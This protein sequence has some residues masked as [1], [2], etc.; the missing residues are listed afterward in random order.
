VER[1]LLP[2][3]AVLDLAL[4][5]GLNPAPLADAGWQIAGLEVP[6]VT[7][8]GT[9]VCD[10]VL[11]NGA[12]GHLLVVEAKSGV[13][14]EPDQARKLAVIDPQDLIV[15]GGITVPQPVP[16]RCEPLFV[17]LS[18]N[19]GRIMIGIGATGLDAPVLAADEGEARLV[20]A[21]SASP[22]LVAVL[23][24]PIALRYPIASIIRFDHQS[25]DDAFDGPVRVE[26]VA[27]MARGRSAVTIRALTEQ[28]TWH[29]AVYGR[30]AQGQLVRKVAAAARRA[31]DADP[32]RLRF[33]PATGNTEAR[34]VILRSPEEFDRRG[35]TQG[36]QAVFGER[37]RRPPP[38]QIPDQLEL[39]SVL[40]DAERATTDDVYESVG[41]GSDDVGGHGKPDDVTGP[42]GPQLDEDGSLGGPDEV[43]AMITR[44]DLARRVPLDGAVPAKSFVVEVHTDDPS[45]Y[46]SEIA[47]RGN[48]EPTKDTYLSRVLVPNGEFWVDR[49]QQRFWVFHTIMP[50]SLAASWLR[51]RVESRRDTD[52][53]WL[54]SSHLRHIAPG[55]APHRV[56]TDFDG[57]RLVAADDAAYDLRVQLT[58]S[59]AERLLDQISAMPEYRAAV[60]FS[61]VEVHL[62]DSELGALREAVKRSGL[63]AARGDDFA[64]HAQFVRSAIGRYARFVETVEAMAMGFSPLPSALAPRMATDGEVSADDYAGASFNGTPIGIRFSRQ[65]AD[66]AGFCEEVFSSRAPFRLWGQPMVADNVA[67]VDAVDLHIGRRLGVEVGRNWMRVYLN[68]GTCGNT[69]ARLISNLQTRFDGALSL[70]SSDLQ[71]AATLQPAPGSVA[72][73]YPPPTEHS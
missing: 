28:V 38:P 40:D 47:G 73:T 56:R 1:R 22:D 59:H 72:A 58:G 55:A 16:L 5:D 30:R 51:D 32:E 34:A 2:V 64:Y 20:N 53:M 44:A 9:V 69:V 27:E 61:S 45:G 49:L 54:P 21:S 31:A 6:V 37:G 15:A 23:G 41:E 10:V 67:F 62:D 25:P 14:V 8:A 3:N 26:L 71:E 17:C 24:E 52:W 43:G 4:V 36:Y 39:F 60:S 42:D 70:T 13:N 7:S 50:S 57:T 66:L 12:T 68:A 19:A 29:F 11:F 35:R 65:I 18:E 33:Q 63:F 46:L 48:V